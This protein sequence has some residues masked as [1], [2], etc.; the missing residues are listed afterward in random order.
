MPRKKS[1]NLTE[2]ELRLMDVVWD[3][4]TATVAEVAEALP[5]ELGLAYN[6]VLTTLRILEEKGYLRHT[7]PDDARAF[8]YTAVVRAGRAEARRSARALPGRVRS[9]RHG[10]GG[11]D[12]PV[13]GCQ[14][15][16]ARLRLARSSTR[17]HLFDREIHR[18]E[19]ER[20]ASQL[21]L[22]RLQQFHRQSRSVDPGKRRR[23]RAA[24]ARGGRAPRTPGEGVLWVRSL[25]LRTRPVLSRSA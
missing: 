17:Q 9:E 25:A 21:V 15:Q 22:L 12:P 14:S 1:A 20:C 6:S 19:E 13:G 11:G 2:A 4:G 24:G 5:K 8:V 16:G 23:H 18:W 7:K 10:H 3:K